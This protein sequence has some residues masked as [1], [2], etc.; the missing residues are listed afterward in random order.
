[1]LVVLYLIFFVKKKSIR[2]K[3]GAGTYLLFLYTTWNS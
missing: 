2:W 1:L 3:L